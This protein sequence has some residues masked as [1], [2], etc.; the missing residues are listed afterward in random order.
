MV[1]QWFE[2]REW[3]RVFLVAFAARFLMFLLTPVDW[4]SD[5]YHH[6]QISYY[7]LKIGLN[8]GRMWDLTGSEYYWG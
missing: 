3:R 2:E 4:N 6:W 8:Q 7:T 5:S 1:L